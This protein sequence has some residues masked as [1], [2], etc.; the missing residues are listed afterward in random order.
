MKECGL[1]QHSQSELDN[2]LRRITK[3]KLKIIFYLKL[4]SK[5][6]SGLEGH[7]IDE[8]SS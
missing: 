4:K 3:K 7:E 1:M 2:E 5:K 6:T 8:Q